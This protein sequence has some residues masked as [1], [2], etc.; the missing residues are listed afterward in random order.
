MNKPEKCCGVEVSARELVV[1]WTGS[2]GEEVLRR[3]AN[4]A[5]G[6]KQLLHAL[7]RGVERVSVCMEATGVYGLDVALFLSAAPR[8]RVMVANPRAVRHFAQ[9]MMKRSKSDV[10]DARVLWEFAQRMPFTEWQRPDEREL[11]LWAVSRRLEALT[12]Q[13]AAEKNRLHAANMSAAL[14]ALVRKSIRGML[15]VIE[16]EMKML[17]Q[18]ARRLIADDARV[19][20]RYRQLRSVTGIG[21]VSAVTLLAE[22]MLLPEDRDVR[23][24]VAFAGLDPREYSSG[25]SVRKQTHISKVGN[26]HLRCALF[27]PALVASRRDPHLRAYYQALLTRGV[28]RKPAVVAVARKLLHAIYGMFKSGSLYDGAKIF[29]GPVALVPRAARNAA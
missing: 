16:R 20:Q 15:R 28:K 21:E 22:L 3:F 25:T 5:A 1:C 10:V 12:K 29:A 13:H 18:Q 2:K 24:W 27:M 14:P 4:T 7:T 9:A 11:A 23:Q 17:R 19:E 6:H 8:V 26:R